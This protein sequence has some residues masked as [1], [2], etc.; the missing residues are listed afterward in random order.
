MKPT[1]R[2][3][4]ATIAT[5]VA[6]QLTAG[7]SGKATNASSENA[8]VTVEAGA[9]HDAGV[10]AAIQDAAV[11]D[12][13][14]GADT[15]EL[16][17]T[18]E[19]DAA[20]IGVGL[21]LD[22]GSDAAPSS[23]CG[24]ALVCGEI[25]CAAD[26]SCADGAQCVPTQGACESSADC[27]HDTQCVDTRC[28]RYGTEAV[29]AIDPTCVLQTDLTNINP[30]VQCQWSGPP[31]TDP[32]PTMNQVMVTPT[33]ADLNLDGD[34]KAFSSSV[35]FASYSLL[36]YQVGYIR[37]ISGTD[38]SQQLTT[39]LTEDSVNPVAPV[40]VADLTGD[41][42]PEIIA[43][44]V[45]GGLV[46]FKVSDDQ[47]QLERLWRSGSCAEGVIT[48]DATG[49]ANRWS[50]P[51]VLDL[52][53]DGT[54]EIVWGATVYDAKGCTISATLGF[55][56]YSQGIFP[57][58]ADVDADGRVE[59]VGGNSLY[60][61]D[62]ELRD[63]IADP[64]FTGPGSYLG[65][66]ALADFGDFP[67]EAL[68]DQDLPEV[69]V[70]SNGQVTVQTLAGTIVFGPIVVPGGG[71]GAPTIADFDGDGHR[72]FAVAGGGA[73]SVFD[74]DC[75]ASAMTADSDAGITSCNTGRTDGILWAQPSNDATSSVTGSSVFDFDAD[76]RSEVVYA[77]QC[78][79]RIYDGATGQVAASIA[80]TSATT[81]ENPVI[82]DTDGDFRSEIVYSANDYYAPQ[83]GCTTTDPLFP[84]T[85]A[86]PTHGVFIL[87]DASDAWAASRPIWNQHAYSVVNVNDDGTIPKTSEVAVNWTDDA[88]N[89]FRQNTQ[90]ELEALG[91]SDLTVSDGSSSCHDES[92]LRANVCNRGT[93]PAPQGVEVQFS[94]N[95]AELCRGQTSKTLEPGTCL[96]VICDPNQSLESGSVDVEADP[97][98]TQQECINQNNR[99]R[100]LLVDCD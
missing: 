84:A 39:P 31:A 12:A 90:G 43:P 57:V 45:G 66:V 23:S 83:L 50:G 40:A 18:L 9:A 7:C 6:G 67:V 64:L 26:E 82:A 30:V 55:P 53:D 71:G 24:E 81:Y 36:D 73:Y 76:G 42:V 97:D 59:W 62:T 32:F 22:A 99:G 72:E 88:L 21:V 13:A 85:A 28:I 70:V 77:D 69:V 78:F 14:M 2:S 19:Q 56:A 8:N 60:E 91:L 74:L 92:V 58:V 25:C 86:A 17:I 63:W 61:W 80:N 68:P 4:W 48:P 44:A 35:I 5:V 51:S 47:T 10:D 65:H 3:A 75:T 1:R 34:A 79:L 15:A 95:D 27:Q 38:C 96:V 37:V 94:V 20:H 52:D 33:V 100:T 16:G 98:D 87:R 29:P 93:L 41:G 49:G 89:N 54:P 46:A 11:Q